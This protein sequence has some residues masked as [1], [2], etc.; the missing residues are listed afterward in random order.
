MTI[1]EVKTLHDAS[2][3]DVPNKLRTLADD[4]EAGR[5]GPKDSTC[6]VCFVGD[7]LCI[8]AYGRESGISDA[9]LVT[10]AATTQ[11]HEAGIN[12]RMI[13]NAET[14]AAEKKP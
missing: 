7:E 1:A 2:M 4:I 12:N 9:C 8:F 10:S 5:Y 13:V 6:V 3:L 14:M 11:L